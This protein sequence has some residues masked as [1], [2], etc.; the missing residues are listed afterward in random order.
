[1]FSDSGD[2]AFDYVK[3]FTYFI[4]ALL[5]SVSLFIFANKKINYDKVNSWFFI[6]LR[7]TIGFYML[8]YGFDKVFKSH[9]PFPSLEKL[10]QTFG[11]SSPQG[12]LWAFMGYST[13]YST[14][15]GIIEVISGAFLLFRKTKAIG[16]L[17]TL[18]IMVNVVLINFSYDVPVKLFAMHIVFFTFLILYPNLRSIINFFFLQKET[19]LLEQIPPSLPQFISNYKKIIKAVVIIGFS[20]VFMNFSITNMRTDGDNAPKPTLYGIYKTEVFQ[21]NADT[22]LPL[23]TD[24]TRWKEIIFDT[25]NTVVKSMTG[26]IMYY[27]TNVDSIG[28]TISFV[29]NLDP[30]QKFQ[31]NYKE[32]NGYLI[33][34]R[35]QKNNL[36]YIKS[37]K[38]DISNFPLVNRRFD[39]VVEYPFNN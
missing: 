9:F 18:M 11:E 36:I 38:V 4:L 23:T 25:K 22:L 30:R 2:T 8:V 37:K 21:L 19:K 13:V 5:T 31:M 12:L 29:S 14:F 15:L 6:F 7:Y 39:W 34:E 26:G 35:E 3:I 28:K 17:L 32:E 24:S 16:A 10:D 33:L 20:I 27:D 1:M